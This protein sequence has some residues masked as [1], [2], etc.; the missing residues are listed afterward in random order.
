MAYRFQWTAPIAVSPH[1][2][3]T[4][5]YGGNVVF[6][7]R[8][9]GQ[10]WTALSGDLTR[11]D[12][13]KQQWAGG[14]I[15]GDNTGVETYDT[16]FVIAESPVQKGVI[17]AGSDDGLIHV[18]RD[19]GAT[20]QNVTAAIRGIPEWGTVSMLEPSHFDAGTVYLTVDAHRLDDTRPYLWKTADFGRTWKRL[21]GSLPRDVYLHSVREDPAAKGTLYL[22]T[23]RGVVF[24]TDDGATWRSLKLNLPTVAVH[25]LQ[26]KDNALVLATHGRSMWI[27]DDLALVRALTPQ[28]TGAEPHLFAA[29]DAVRWSVAPTRRGDFRAANPPNGAV[30][31]YWLKDEPKGDVTLEI[32]DAQGTVVNTLSSKPRELTGSTEYTEEEKEGLESYTLSKKAGVQRA[33]WDLSWAGAEMIP[34]AKLDSG[35]PLIGPE[36]LEGTYTARLTVDGKSWTVPFKLLPDPRATVSAQDLDEQLRFSLQVRDEITRLTR[37]AVRLQTVRKQLA[38]RNDL[39]KGNAQAEP[40]VKGSQELIAK[41]DDLEARLQNPRAEIVYDILAQKGGAR[42]YSRLAPLLDYVKTGDGPPTQGMRQVFAAESKELDGYVAELQGLLGKDLAA[43][44]D[45]AGKLGLPVIYLP[46]AS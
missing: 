27:F 45:S 15:T 14:P 29:P 11:N 34:N 3:K 4:V 41:L 5:Y 30:F 26:V 7:T 44:N 21:D 35:Y 17:W 40:L 9:G 22:G 33:V 24:S 36:A 18:S 42:L 1:D 16:V 12:K 20:W 13:S 23:E 46:P 43:L 25:D 8:D 37:T 28:A 38:A 32:L 39:L 19:D 31:Y 10:T 6:R 2:P